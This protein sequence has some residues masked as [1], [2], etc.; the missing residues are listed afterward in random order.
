MYL[1]RA[2]FEFVFN[3]PERELPWWIDVVYYSLILPVYQVFLLLYGFIFGQFKFFWE[4]EK[5][6]IKRVKSWFVS[7]S[8]EDE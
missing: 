7:K 8:K 5:R 3:E 4:F 6:F 2:I 1:K